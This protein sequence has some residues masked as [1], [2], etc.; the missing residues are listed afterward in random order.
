LQRA[1]VRVV[2]AGRA[3]HVPRMGPPTGALKR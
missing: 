3:R 2:L 1:R